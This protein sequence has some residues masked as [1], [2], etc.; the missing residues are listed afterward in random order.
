V[1]AAG[2]DRALEEFVANVSPDLVWITDYRYILPPSIIAKPRLGVVNLHPS[3]LP[4]YRGRAPINWAIIQG[5]TR[6]GL[7]AHF[8]DEGVD[9]GDIIEQVSYELTMEQDVGDALDALYPLYRELTR[10]VIDRLATGD[11]AR[12]RQDHSLATVFPRRKP[13]DGRIDWRVPRRSVWNLIRAVAHPYPGAFTSG[14]GKRLT[15]W[16][17]RESDHESPFDTLPGTIIGIDDEGLHVQCGDLALL[18]TKI[19]Y[20]SGESAALREG[21]VLGGDGE[22]P[23][24]IVSG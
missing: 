17:A 1:R 23:P 21:A 19:E 16:K 15:I 14:T 9:S 13:E 5:E 6:L 20:G 12:I 22:E 11:V 7:T 3:L 24:E 2:R 18:L 10:R 4:K 8:V